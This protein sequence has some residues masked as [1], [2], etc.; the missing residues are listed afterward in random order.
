MLKKLFKLPDEKHPFLLNLNFPFLH[1]SHY[2]TSIVQHILKLVI[3]KKLFFKISYTVLY[4][5][6]VKM[7][8]NRTI[9]LIPKIFLCLLPFIEWH[10]M[11]KTFR[12]WILFLSIKHFS[13]KHKVIV[14]AVVSTCGYRVD[15]FWQMPFI[16]S[17]LRL[18]FAMPKYS[19][20]L[21]WT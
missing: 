11:R 16:L 13:P 19:E 7:E 9:L 21:F 14:R 18:P 12:K 3:S 15:H 4:I 2:L 5:I 20:D 1:L 17:A 10:Y 6:N 8:P